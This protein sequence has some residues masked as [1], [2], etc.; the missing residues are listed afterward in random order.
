MLQHAA[1]C[2]FN[3]QNSSQYTPVEEIIAVFGKSQR[4]LFLVK[5]EGHPGEDSCLPEHSLLEDGC[6]DSIDEFWHKSGLNPALDFYPDPHNLPRCWMCGYACKNPHPKYL[7]AHI[8]RNGH[9]WYQGHSHRKAKEA[10]KIECE[11][12]KTIAF[13]KDRDRTFF[14]S[15]A[16]SLPTLLCIVA[17]NFSTCLGQGS[18]QV[19]SVYVRCAWAG[20][21]YCIYVVRPTRVF[22]L[23]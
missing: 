20:M 1:H 2:A 12:S 10:V 8:T 7:K 15:D 21:L 3:Y 16:C 22:A 11:F 23:V 4:K 13:P 17:P 9:N 6:K 18:S 14:Q 5:W 19:S